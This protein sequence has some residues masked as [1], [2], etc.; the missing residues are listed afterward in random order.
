MSEVDQS[1][2][3]NIGNNGPKPPN[4]RYLIKNRPLNLGLQTTRLRLYPNYNTCQGPG[5]NKCYK[6]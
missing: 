3:Q 5:L 1:D 2:V 4:P 6:A